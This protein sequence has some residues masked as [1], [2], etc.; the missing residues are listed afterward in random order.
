[1]S[2]IASPSPESVLRPHQAEV[3]LDAHFPH[4]GW[5]RAN[6]L[7]TVLRDDLWVVIQGPDKPDY[8]KLAHPVTTVEKS[9]E[10]SASM[11]GLKQGNAFIHPALD[12]VM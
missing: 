4:M 12:L 1:M 7:Y 2:D 6:Q 3:R 10:S 11:F 8:P 5:G 9:R